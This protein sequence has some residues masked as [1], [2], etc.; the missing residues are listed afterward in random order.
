MGLTLIDST[1]LKGI[2]AFNFSR[3]N[4]TY[5]SGNLSAS[6]VGKVITISRMPYGLLVGNSVRISGGTGTDEAVPIT[7]ISGVGGDSSGTITV[8]TA[9]AHTGAW[10]VGSAN[11]GV[12]ESVVVGG[13]G[14]SIQ[15]PAGTFNFYSKVNAP[16]TI[17]IRG[18]GAATVISPQGV[19]SGVFNFSGLFVDFGSMFIRYPI[20]TEVGMGVTVQLTG[21]DS[22]LISNLKIWNGWIPLDCLNCVSPQLTSLDFHYSGAFA[23][24]WKSNVNSGFQLSN[25]EL[26]LANPAGI[27]LQIEPISTGCRIVN[28]GFGGGAYSIE[29]FGSTANTVNEV[30]ISDCWLDAYTTVGFRMTMSNA[31]SVANRVGLRNCILSGLTNSTPILIGAAVAGQIANLNLQDLDAAFFGTGDGIYLSGTKGC[32]ISNVTARSGD[33]GSGAGLHLANPVNTD[34]QVEGGSFGVDGDGGSIAPAARGVLIDAGAQGIR[35]DGAKLA[36]SAALVTNNS[37]DLA[38]VEFTDTCR[39]LP[40]PVVASAAAFPIP[41]FPFFFVSGNTGV[42][43]VT[44]LNAAHVGRSG[45]FIATHA[46]PG[47]WTAGG[48]IG[49][50]FTPTQNKITNW[51]VLDDLKIYLS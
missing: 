39:P 38:N 41:A 8:T 16:D 47:A 27:V 43:S 7:A 37:T 4:G 46:T 40:S 30:Q 28:V 2:G 35:V 33:A 23:T 10:I 24:H 11:A 36:G 25:S 34:V 19:F 5:A 29:L 32:V 51:V 13:P 50:T 45:K 18:A 21:V 26:H 22:G 44:G 17:S 15:I 12:Q 6:G 9:N 42:T 49:N 3:I 1:Q 20:V 31:G 14:C 48:T